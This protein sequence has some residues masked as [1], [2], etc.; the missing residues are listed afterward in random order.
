MCRHNATCDVIS[1][2]GIGNL[3]M[4]TKRL[5][6]ARGIVRCSLMKSH[7]AY[8]RSIFGIKLNPTLDKMA[9]TL[10]TITL[11]AMSPVKIKLGL[12][13]LA[14]LATHIC[15][16]KE[17]WASQLCVHITKITGN[18]F[19]KRKKQI[20]YNFIFRLHSKQWVAYSFIA[21]IFLIGWDKMGSIYASL[22]WTWIRVMACR[23]PSL[24]KQ[25][26]TYGKL[27]IRTNHHQWNFHQKYLYLSRKCVSKYR[28]RNAIHFV[29]TLVC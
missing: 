15:G 8:R 18:V 16:T 1:G 14:S 9:A 23:L 11:S 28:R 20:Q 2:R 6:F 3:C 13:I 19:I 27:N 22:N 25:M 7:A 5:T 17:R 29:K 12:I 26:L 24:P 4:Q 21:N 10:Q